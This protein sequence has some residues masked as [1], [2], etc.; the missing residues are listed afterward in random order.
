MVTKA[1]SESRGMLIKP[2]YST[3]FVVHDTPAVHGAAASGK[4]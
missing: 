2:K 1:M 4:T 3:N